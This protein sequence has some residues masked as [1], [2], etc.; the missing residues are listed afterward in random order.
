MA[1]TLVRVRFRGRLCAGPPL[2][3]TLDEDSYVT[4]PQ[5]FE[6]NQWFFMYR[7]VPSNLSRAFGKTDSNMVRKFARESIETSSPKRFGRLA[8]P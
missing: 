2:H 6:V 4:D 8:C 7:T 5:I 3:E 1:I